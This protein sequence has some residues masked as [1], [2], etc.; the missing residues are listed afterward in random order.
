MTFERWCDWL[1][2]TSGFFVVFGVVAAIAPDSPPFSLWSDAVDATY[3]PGEPHPSAQALRRF[4]MAPLG[5]TIAGSYL[6]QAFIVAYPFR[7]GKPWA[8][9]A[10]LAS[11][12][13]WFV[14]D[15]GMS[16]VHGAYFNIFM[17]NLFP[18]AIFGIP[19]FATRSLAR[20]P[21]APVSP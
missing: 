21:T 14:V 17:I 16:L 19:L 10:I 20:R 8:W 4:M 15:S 11:T 7:Q 5:A 9:Y 18:L 12:L 2:Y 13:L 6:L 3:F 1:L